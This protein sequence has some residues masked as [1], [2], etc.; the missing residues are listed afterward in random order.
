MI[1]TTKALVAVAALSMVVAA[2]GTYQAQPAGGGGD[3]AGAACLVGDETCYETGAEGN[4]AEDVFDAESVR[5]D[6]H[7]LLGMYEEDLPENVRISRRGDEQMIL[8]ED[9]VHGRLTVEL[10]DTDGSGFRVVTVTVELPNGP[11]TFELT[12]G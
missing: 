2:C 8:T 4:G 3:A 9:Y 5:Q 7:G 12:P 11:A 6:A 1:N 10:D